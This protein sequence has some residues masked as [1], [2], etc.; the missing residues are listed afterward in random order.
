MDTARSVPLP[1]GEKTAALSQATRHFAESPARRAEE[2]AS[3]R[4]G[5][6][7]GTK[8][9]DTAEMYSNGSAEVLVTGAI[10]GRR[11]E[12]FLLDKVLPHHATRVG[13]VRVYA[14][15]VGKLGV[16]Y[17]NLHL[18]H[19][20]DRVPLVETIE[21]FDELKLDGMIRHW[22]VSNF[23]IADVIEL[24]GVPGGDAVQANQILCLT[25]RG[26]EYALLPWRSQLGIPT[27]A[28]SPIEQVRLLGCPGPQPIALQH[29]ATPAQIALAWALQHDRV[30]AI[31]AP[32]HLPTFGK[33][34]QP[35]TST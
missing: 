12:V 26:S 6:D 27:M 15:S 34:P 14:A 20:R 30:N 33:T 32:E 13:T 28:D 16:D 23:D 21:G 31:P 10:A 18:L 11:S 4:L 24:T 17:I 5:V 2:V 3:I 25:R 9:I 22:G 19:W 35:E 29:N 7:L 8:V 1:S